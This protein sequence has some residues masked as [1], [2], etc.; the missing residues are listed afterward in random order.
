MTPQL[1]ELTQRNA[2]RLQQQACRQLAAVCTLSRNV[3]KLKELLIKRA[4]TGR[5]YSDEDHLKLDI[6]ESLSGL[7][8]SDRSIDE[9]MDNLRHDLGIEDEDEDPADYSYDLWKT[10]EGR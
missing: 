4:D 9:H 7:F 3:D 2:E 10:A 6:L 1:K 5:L 8:D